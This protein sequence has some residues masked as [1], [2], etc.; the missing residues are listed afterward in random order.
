[1][2][3]SFDIVVGADRSS[4]NVTAI[5]YESHIIRQDERELFQI[6][7]NSQLLDVVENHSGNRPE[8]VN[9]TNSDEPW[10]SLYD[11]YDW[12]PVTS[13]YMIKDI[14][15]T[16]IKQVPVIIANKVFENKSR[17]IATYNAS[18]SDSVAN[19][20]ESTW[21]TSNKISAGFSIKGKVQ[22][23]GAEVEPSLSFGF[24]HAWGKGGTTRQMTTVGSTTGLSVTLNPNESVIAELVATRGKM[25]VKIKYYLILTGFAAVN[26]FPE[27]K[28]HYFWAYPINNIL[29]GEKYK[30]ITENIQIDY[31]SNA[32]VVL[33]DMKTS[34][35]L[36]SKS[37]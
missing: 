23:Y 35:V 20:V 3:I 31:Y 5:G 29:N 24:E 37:F 17:K 19:T 22:V 32:K 4:S 34:R 7:K 33:K 6:G 26:Y 36:Q 1:M 27:F 28:G 25:N 18:I 15:V 30:V 14:V 16:E 12:Q 10:G 2:P 13:N 8:D 9:L 21:N 11:K